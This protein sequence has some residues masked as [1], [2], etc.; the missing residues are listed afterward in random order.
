MRMMCHLDPIHYRLPR[1]RSLYDGVIIGKR[2]NCIFRQETSKILGGARSAHI[3]FVLC[4]AASTLGCYYSYI[5]LSGANP[6]AG[7][8]A[9]GP[10]PDA[11]V[12]LVVIGA[13]PEN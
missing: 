8:L 7:P 1:K 2:H 11:G 12:L 3:V 4:E 13:W 5:V 9:A 6:G 10:N